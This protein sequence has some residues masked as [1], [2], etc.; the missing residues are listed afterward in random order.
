M[1]QVKLLYLIHSIL[2]QLLHRNMDLL[3]DIL[4]NDSLNIYIPIYDLPFASPPIYQIV[5]TS[6]K[7][8]KDQLVAFQKHLPKRN[9]FSNPF[10]LW[11]ITNSNILLSGLYRISVLASICLTQ[12][13]MMWKFINFQLRR[14]REHSSPPQPVKKKFMTTKG[15]PS[16]KERG[17]CFN[18]FCILLA[19]VQRGSS[20]FAQLGN[21]K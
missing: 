16:K 7:Q 2:I 17:V 19:E 18:D 5:Y 21:Y 20:C 8:I 15:K 9:S 13:F 4:N 12:A 6:N 14:W 1:P 10:H 11:I 3:C